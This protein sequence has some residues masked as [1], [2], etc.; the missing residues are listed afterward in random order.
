MDPLLLANE[1]QEVTLDKYVAKRLR[2]T[3]SLSQLL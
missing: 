2:A 3:C 1:P